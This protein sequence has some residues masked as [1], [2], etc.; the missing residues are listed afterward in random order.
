MAFLS[1]SSL[2]LACM[3]CLV[4]MPGWAS[5]AV[6]QDQQEQ[7]LTVH[8]HSGREFT[9]VVDPRTGPRKLWLRFE[10]RSAQLVRP[11]DW[12]AVVY[13]EY[14]GKEVPTE[15]LYQLAQSI[16]T[17]ETVVDQLTTSAPADQQHAVTAR[18]ILFVKPVASLEASARVGNWDADRTD[19]GLLLWANPLD[20]D[21]SSM[22]VPMRLEV[23]LEATKDFHRDDWDG[24][25]QR[26]Y[27][28]AASVTPGQLRSG[29][30]A[31]LAF[32]PGYERWGSMGRVI[33]RAVI[34]GHGV[35]EREAYVRLVNEFD[36]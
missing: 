10:G 7:H 36:R 16:K 34:P 13:A 29:I 6:A 26:V 3:V 17:T 30:P 28:W 23:T 35:F 18:K 9:A 20:A 5:M 14:A 21:G 33:V 27:H 24:S 2:A 25:F 22:A 1:R 32:P 31:K 4:S 8:L 15:S 11:I 19:D 12:E